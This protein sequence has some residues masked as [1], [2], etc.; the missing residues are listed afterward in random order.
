MR[1]P[2]SETT[3]AAALDVPGSLQS[4]DA[5]LGRELTKVAYQSHF[6]LAQHYSGVIFQA[7]IAIITMIV[8]AVALGLDILASAK[9]TQITWIGVPGRGLAVYAAAVPINLL[10]AMEVSYLKRFYQI[11][12]AEYRDCEWP[13]GL[14]LQL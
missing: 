2:P 6:A 9:F 11:G 4:T 8:I 7:R 14:L 1:Q 13:Q 12:W 10:H 3:E 5:D